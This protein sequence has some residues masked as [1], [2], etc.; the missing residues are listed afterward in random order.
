[1][2]A[3]EV[4]INRKSSLKAAFTNQKCHP[5]Y[6]R[7]D[8]ND[9]QEKEN[10]KHQITVKQRMISVFKLCVT[11]LKVYEICFSRTTSKVI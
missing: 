5:D 8:Q 11:A 2:S 9:C 1:M 3:N 7:D 10:S 6:L 4:H